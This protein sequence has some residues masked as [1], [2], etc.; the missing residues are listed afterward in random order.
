MQ[1]RGFLG[2]PLEGQQDPG[3]YQAFNFSGRT[4]ADLQ[5]F[6]ELLLFIYYFI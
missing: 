3:V 4:L 6:G 1:G 5:N 2:E